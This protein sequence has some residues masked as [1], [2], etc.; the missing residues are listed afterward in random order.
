MQRAASARSN[1]HQAITRASR[2]TGEP[3]LRAV[4]AGSGWS[5]TPSKQNRNPSFSAGYSVAASTRLV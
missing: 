3:V 1:L 4:V 2:I 5:R